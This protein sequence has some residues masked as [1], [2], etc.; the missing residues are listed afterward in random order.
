M[1]KEDD[2]V[3]QLENKNYNKSKLPIIIVCIVLSIVL[4]FGGVW[5]TFAFAFPGKLADFAYARNMDG[6]ATKLYTRDYNKSK[7][8]NSL[9]MALNL[10]IKHEKHELVVSEFEELYKSPYYEDFIKEVNSSNLNLNEKPIVKASL[11][12]EDNF[13]KN[14]YIKS[15]VAL[16]ETNKAFDFAKVDRLNLNPTFEDFGNYLFGELANDLSK[17][18]SRFNEV[19]DGYSEPLIAVIEEYFDALD[20][21]FDGYLSADKTH[22]FAMGDRILQVGESLIKFYK[23]DEIGGARDE[24]HVKE[25]MS[26]VNKNFKILVVE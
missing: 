18:A 21:E 8:I 23:N 7:D 19:I 10:N 5:L 4:I 16:G 24:Q 6:Y 22:A 17:I 13:L 11:L 12:N 14:K 2:V 9:Y 25:V 3:K 15:L 20:A 26:K 1:T